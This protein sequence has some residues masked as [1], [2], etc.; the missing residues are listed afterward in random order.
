MT[1]FN[2]IF[3]SLFSPS[4]DCWRKRFLVNNLFS[5]L[6]SPAHTHLRSV[7]NVVMST[8]SGVRRTSARSTTTKN[9]PAEACGPCPRR[10]TFR[11]DLNEM[12]SLF[13]SLVGVWWLLLLA[14]GHFCTN[15]ERFFFFKKREARIRSGP[16]YY[17]LISVAFPLCTTSFFE[18]EAA[19][20]CK[21][22][23]AMK[24]CHYE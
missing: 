17:F 4:K 2:S 21:H 16:S 18:K 3:R 15:W 24:R 1:T 10:T 22:G 19:V 7:D 12:R 6:T 23:R 9:C 14:A 5:S 13:F 8:G 11:F 20:D